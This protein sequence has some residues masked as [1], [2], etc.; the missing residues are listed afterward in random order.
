MATVTPATTGT[1]TSRSPA[2]RLYDWGSHLIDQ[3]LSLHPGPIDHV[4]CIEHKRKWHDVTNADHTTV[5]LR[6][7]DGT[8]A[9]FVH[10]DL[11]AALKP[12]WYLLG[13][14]GA[15]TSTWRQEQRRP[16]QRCRHAG[17]GCARRHRL[18]ARAHL[19]RP[20]RLTDDP[21]AGHAPSRTPST[22]SSSTRVRYGWPM[23]VTRR[24]VTPGGRRDGGRARLSAG[25][26]IPDAASTGTRDVG[27]HRPRPLGLSRRRLRRLARGRPRP[28]MPAPTRSCSRSPPETRHAPSRWSPEVVPPATT[29][30]CSTT[31]RWRRSTSR[32]RTRR[33]C[34][35]SRQRWQAGKHVLCE[36]PIT[37]DAAECRRAFDAAR[38]ADLLLVEAAWTQWHPRTQRVDA[39]VAAGDARARSAPSV[40]PSPSM[41]CPHDNYRLDPTR[42]GGSLLDVGP[43]SSGQRHVG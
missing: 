39:L 3:I 4:T 27:R 36:K 11:A 14:E 17:R 26:R 6:F 43:T 42:G 24:A 37:L 28:C 16:P 19:R 40:H 23:S 35:G 15:I 38:E 41:A 33:T 32:S 12:R 7:R 31:T 1:P 22:A 9:V 10:S 34:T 5:A 25:R 20:L 21:H 30:R 2:A 29:A 8:E 18:T 13:T